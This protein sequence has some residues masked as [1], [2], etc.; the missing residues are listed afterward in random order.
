VTGPAPEPI[1]VAALRR[2]LAAIEHQRWADWQRWMH[3]QCERLPSGELVIPASLVDR[4][5]RQIATPFEALS[6]AEQRSDLEQV[7]RYWPLIGPALERIP[8]LE[9]Q[10]TNLA[11]DLHSQDADYWRQRADQVATA[12]RPFIVCEVAGPLESRPRCGA[13]DGC[14]LRAALADAPA[15]GREADGAALISTERQRQVEAEGWTPEHDDRLELGELVD[16][17][18][19]YARLGRGADPAQAR[20]E[21]PWD[22]GFKPA[23]N[24]ERDLVRAGAL[25]AAEIDRLR[26]NAPVEDERDAQEG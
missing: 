14:R 15:P 16:A 5:E 11:A 4:W 7:D 19:A 21:W 25:I 20:I 2:Q 9:R 3:E 13:C 6:E 26:R 18:I 22:G 1:D 24:A 12:S 10:V 23:T 17:A 8:E